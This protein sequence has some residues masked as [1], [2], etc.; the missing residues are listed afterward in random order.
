MVR[1]G[2]TQKAG[3]SGQRSRA[4]K[5]PNGAVKRNR[6]VDNSSCPIVGIGGSAGGFEAA[7]ELLRHLP[8]NNGMA[9][10]I[11]QHLDPHHAS[12]L[13]GLLGK[14]TQMPVIELASKTVP[15]PNMVYVQPPNK[16][17]IVE[18]DA[19]ALIPRTD[20]LNLAID[21]FFESLAE[22]RGSGSIGVLLSGTGSDGT[23]G[24]RAIKA[25]G[26]LT[27]AQNIATAKF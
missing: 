12:K 20:R 24:L 1:K 22:A 14:V 25:A 3:T 27:F 18:D 26:G 6:K 13:A 17:V 10:V 11:V 19:L 16:C 2:K 4:N 5:P 15:S 21:H 8:P 23:A 9:F 7:L